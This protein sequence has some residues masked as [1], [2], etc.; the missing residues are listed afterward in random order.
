VHELAVIQGVVDQ[1][2]ARLGQTRVIEVHLTIGRLS[3]V[4]PDALRF[5]F[6][7]AAAGTILDG[8]ALEI[9]EP[10]GRARCRTCQRDFTV[11]RPILLCPCGSADVQVISGQEMLIRSV[12]VA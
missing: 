3:G 5:C 4:V 7:L 2:T 11:A 6:D 12:K 9:D 8:A 10:D 1:V